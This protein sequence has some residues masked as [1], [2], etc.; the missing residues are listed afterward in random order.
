MTDPDLLRAQ[1]EKI[2]R[3]GLAVTVADVQPFT[4]SMAAPIRNGGGAVIAAV[5]FIYRKALARN[6]KR[7]EA[8]QDQLMHMAH[9]ISIDLGWRPHRG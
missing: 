4:G 8:L 1:L 2:R 7:R 3:S 6:D 9:S 5:C